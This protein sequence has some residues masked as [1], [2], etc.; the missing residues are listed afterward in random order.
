ML[1]CQVYLRRAVIVYKWSIM[2]HLSG[3][4]KYDHISSVFASV[5]WLHATPDFKLLLLSYIAV[6]GIAPSYFTELVFPYE[7]AGSLC[8]Q[9]TGLLTVLRVKR[10]TMGAHGF[11]LVHRLCCIWIR[12]CDF[13]FF[14]LHFI[15]FFLPTLQSPVI[16][17][18]YVNINI[19]ENFY[20][21]MHTPLH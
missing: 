21:S 5:L 20:K 18:C 2:Q 17:T 14:Q 7:P 19:I 6:N 13:C 12:I 15:L 4:N 1:F 10:K 11:I 3:S 16:L 8:F 9:G